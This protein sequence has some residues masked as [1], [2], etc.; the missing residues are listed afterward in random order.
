MTA[1]VI[2]LLERYG[3]VFSLIAMICTILILIGSVIFVWP[4]PTESPLL[5]AEWSSSYGVKVDENNLNLVNQS[6]SRPINITLEVYNTGNAPAHGVGVSFDYTMGI[7]HSDYLL[8]Y[9]NDQYRATTYSNV[10][11]LGLLQEGSC[12][13]VVVLFRVSFY[14]IWNSSSNPKLNF[15]VFSTEFPTEDIEIELHLV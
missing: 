13:T 8:I 9:E 1:R 6:Q 3:P 7:G 14:G 12:F 10:Y 5:E 15:R 2:N 4:P 11:Q